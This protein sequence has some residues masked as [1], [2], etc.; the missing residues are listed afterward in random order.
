MV[1]LSHLN[2]LRAL[3]ASVREGSFKRAAEELGVT[4][5]AVG[6]Q[7]RK[8]EASLGQPLLR[9]NANGFEPTQTAISACAK[10]AAG[11]EE[12]REALAIISRDPA[13]NRLFVTVT[14]SIGERW[15]APRLASF[16][17]SNSEVDLRIDT[18]PYVLHRV[19]PEFDF[20]IR[21]DRPGQSGHEELALFGEV[22]IPVCTPAVA[23]RI[24]PTDDPD[25]LARAPLINVDRSTDDPDWLHW[26]EWGKRFGYEIPMM[27][28]RLHTT[29]TTLAL[30]ALYDGHGLHLA[31]LSISLPDLLSGRLV[32]PF[33]ARACTRPG[34]PYSLISVNPDRQ[35]PILRA[36]R[37]WVVAEAAKTQSAMES[38]L[39]T[40]ARSPGGR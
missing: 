2:A 33:G 16:L 35:K 8:L 19:D 28:Q 18:T 9:R 36:F 4:P 31:Q 14:P 34:Y 12:L 30:R 38:F 1:P 13:P 23:Q 27:R 15:L 39:A 29:Y 17:A 3:E 24:G 5:A 7:V 20:A 22:L 32:A 26:D 11:F 21:Y 10:L 25:C 37:E 6:Q 40:E